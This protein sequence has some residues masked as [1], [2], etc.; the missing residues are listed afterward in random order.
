LDYLGKFDVPTLL[1]IC[2]LNPEIADPNQI[3]AGQQLHL[4]LY[5]Q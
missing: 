2:A 5:L 4:P 1:D 3:H